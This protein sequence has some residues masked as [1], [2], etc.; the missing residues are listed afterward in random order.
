MALTSKV[1]DVLPSPGSSFVTAEAIET[2]LNRVAQD[3]WE[4][5]RM[6]EHYGEPASSRGIGPDLPS[7]PG[8]I[9]TTLLF[10]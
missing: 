6:A 1:I 10:K 5:L 3:G 8:R 7:N 9:A 4:L 2:A